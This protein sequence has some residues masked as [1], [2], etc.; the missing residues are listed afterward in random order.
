MFQPF[1]VFIVLPLNFIIQ[2]RVFCL[3]IVHVKCVSIHDRLW[4]RI[5]AQILIIF[6][7]VWLDQ[8]VVTNVLEGALRMD[9]SVRLKC[10]IHCVHDQLMEC[11]LKYMVDEWSDRLPHLSLLSNV[12]RWRH[13]FHFFNLF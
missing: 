4:L 6:A 12:K 7:I 10:S 5:K 2:D 8:F 3:C 1:F 11:L 13:I 9:D